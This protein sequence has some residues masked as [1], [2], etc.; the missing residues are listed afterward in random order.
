MAALPLVFIIMSCLAFACIIALFE[1]QWLALN[2]S[3]FKL[4]M[5][6]VAMGED[7]LRK[8]WSGVRE[9]YRGQFA[10]SNGTVD[11][12]TVFYQLIGSLL[13]TVSFALFGFADFHLLCLTLEGMGI[14]ASHLEPPLGAGTLTVLSLSASIVFFGTLLLDLMGMTRIAPWRERISPAW[15]KVM[16]C[17]CIF[18][19]SLSLLITTLSGAWRGKSLIEEEA[20]LTSDGVFHHLG[21]DSGGLTDS[22]SIYDVNQ[23]E[24]PVLP[25][26][27]SM[28][29]V[30]LVVNTALP[31][32][33]LIGSALSGYGLVS[34]AKFVLLGAVFVFLSPTGILLIILAFIARVIER[35]YDVA[36]ALIRVLG[37]MGRWLMGLVHYHPP[38]TSHRGSKDPRHT[39]DTASGDHDT[40]GDDGNTT[41]N[42]GFNPYGTSTEKG[43]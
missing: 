30:P 38:D 19:L 33:F 27:S 1:S 6:P 43:E 21:I 29:W 28:R 2:E 24:A 22:D 9:F 4:L 13:Y 37:S 12:T 23:L 34:L 41:M 14:E 15:T 40:P 18:C 11:P 35:I 7:S 36:I 32:L 42:S 26:E 3:I 39:K 5:I 8:F 16:Y 10:E 17:L 25:E 20:V 31:A